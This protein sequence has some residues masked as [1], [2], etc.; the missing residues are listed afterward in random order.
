MINIPYN[1]LGKSLFASTVTID[2]D[3]QTKRAKIEIELPINQINSDFEFE[4]YIEYKGTDCEIE[5]IEQNAKS[6]IGTIT[7]KKL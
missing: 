1:N 4:N 3:R 7:I 6:N 5:R 2:S